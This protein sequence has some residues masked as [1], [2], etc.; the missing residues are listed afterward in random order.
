MSSSLF[1]NAVR[2]F[3]KTLPQLQVYTISVVVPATRTGFFNN[4]IFFLPL[5]N[6][7]ILGHYLIDA[8]GYFPSQKQF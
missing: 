7:F 1:F 3:E 2:E 4:S 6:L 5:K 8:N